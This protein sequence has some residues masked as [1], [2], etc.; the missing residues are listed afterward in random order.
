MLGTQLLLDLRGCDKILLDDANL[1]KKLMTHAAY[2]AGATIVGK[3]FHKFAPTGVT[4]FVAIAE[5]HLSIHTWPEH[6]YAAVDIFTCG[7]TF[8][9]DQAANLIINQLKCSQPQVTELKRGL[10]QKPS[11]NIS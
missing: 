3:S 6:G 2:Q 5:S 10:D 8:N 11:V 1:I 7:E 9:P 4:G